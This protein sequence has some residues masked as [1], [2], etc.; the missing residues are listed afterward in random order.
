MAKYF[1]S[2][3][4]SRL[5]QIVTDELLRVKEA[6][7]HAENIETLLPSHEMV[8]HLIVDLRNEKVELES[9]CQIANELI[10]G[11]IDV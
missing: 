7:E 5:I 1:N 10:K 8:D 11:D 4:L 2:A 9:L 6:L 3:Q